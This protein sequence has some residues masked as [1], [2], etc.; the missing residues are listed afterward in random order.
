MMI[1]NHKLKLVG[2]TP[3][4]PSGGPVLVLRRVWGHPEE[5][6]VWTK[7]D[8]RVVGPD[9]LVAGTRVRRGPHAWWPDGEDVRGTVAGHRPSPGYGD[10]PEVMVHWDSVRPGNQDCWSSVEALRKTWPDGCP[11]RYRHE[12]CEVEV[13]PA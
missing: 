11:Y 5:Q 9:Q 13:V 6:L 12:V 7:D 10:I 1:Y 4:W 8:C 2:S 3:H